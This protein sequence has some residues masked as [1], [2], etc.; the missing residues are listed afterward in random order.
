MQSECD[1]LGHHCA[2]GRDA[3][4]LR[5]CQGDICGQVASGLNASLRQ[6]QGEEGSGR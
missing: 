5:V 1:T 2:P 3:S 6:R 4:A